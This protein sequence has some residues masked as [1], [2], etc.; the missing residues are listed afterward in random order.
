MVSPVVE[1]TGAR[2]NEIVL[3]DIEVLNK[4]CDH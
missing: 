1:G 2:T 3:D 4:S